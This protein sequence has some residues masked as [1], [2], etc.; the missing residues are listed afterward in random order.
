MLKKKIS[1]L[2]CLFF[3]FFFYIRQISDL[4]M[5]TICMDEIGYWANAAFWN[6]WNWSSVMSNFAPYY[7]YGY[8]IVLFLL[9]K[10]F[11]D[12]FLLHQAAIIVN[13]VMIICG[14]C[15]MTRIV[16]RFF[17]QVNEEVRNIICL[18][19][20]FY[21]SVQHHTL[22]AWTETYL[23]F[24]F[25][26]SI[27][28]LIRVFEK[29]KTIYYILFALVLMDMYITHQRSIAI[30]ILGSSLILTMTILKRDRWKQTGIFIAV[31]ILCVVGSSLMKKSIYKNVYTD[32][33]IENETDEEQELKYLNDYQGQIRKVQYIFSKEGFGNLLIS[34]IGKIYYFIIA[35]FMIGGMGLWY[36]I[37][38]IIKYF[39]RKDYNNLEG[40][41]YCYIL[42]AYLG[43]TLIAAV[44]MIA[45]SRLDTVAYGRYT[46]WIGIIII[47]FGLFNLLLSNIKEKAKIIFPQIIFSLIFLLVFENY[48]E[49]Y[50]ISSYFPTCSQIFRYFAFQVADTKGMLM[51]MTETMI[52][53]GIIIGIL[54]LVEHSY[55]KTIFMTVLLIC[56]WTNITKPAIDGIFSLQHESEVRPI[57]EYIQETSDM[58]IY[59]LYDDSSCNM[60]NLW[61]GSIQYLLLDRS[62]YCIKDITRVKDDP[63]VIICENALVPQGYIV[64]CETAL[65]KVIRKNF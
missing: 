32:L 15:I 30:V 2:G 52:T 27:V 24:L 33:V 40:F 58:Q 26:I 61:T 6:G 56:F 45:P 50:N 44:F 22:V 55:L 16:K 9:M 48:I 59:Y 17:F 28:L 51:C 39:R 10:C 35:S 3:L 42:G 12:P 37:Y 29:R 65:Y 13:I 34:Y 53:G 47:T 25:L 63:L 57:V 62:L 5:P 31:I 1:F 8:S 49:K 19:P 41:V 54:T 21:P 11:K 36:L 64:E 43:T 38:G 14:Y 18:I 60:S 46:E 7:S 4:V 20:F 23:L